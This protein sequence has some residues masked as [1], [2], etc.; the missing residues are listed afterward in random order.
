[1]LELLPESGAPSCCWTDEGALSSVFL[2]LVS[3]PEEVE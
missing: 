1:M 2:M 3:E